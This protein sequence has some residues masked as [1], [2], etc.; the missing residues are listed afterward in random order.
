[1][2]KPATQR[3]RL[4]PRHP[5]QASAEELAALDARSEAEL[6]AAAEADPNNLPLDEAMLTRMLPVVDVRRLRR[7]LGLSQRAFARR[8]RLSVGTVRDWE[9][10]R[11]LPDQ[12]ARVLLNLIERDAARVAQT[13]DELLAQITPENLPESFDVRPVGGEAL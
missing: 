7:R 2:S 3:F 9:Q 1:V 10:G 12:P 13:L 4:D 11:S 5:A 6:L 8:Y